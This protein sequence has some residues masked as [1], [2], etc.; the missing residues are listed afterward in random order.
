VGESIFGVGVI[1]AIGIGSLILCCLILL[2]VCMAV[3]NIG[4]TK[5]GVTIPEGVVKCQSCSEWAVWLES[6]ERLCAR[7]LEPKTF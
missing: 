5:E 1:L 6:G 2:V 3:F 4:G 7:C